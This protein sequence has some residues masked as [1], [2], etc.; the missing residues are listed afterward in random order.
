MY[1]AL[2]HREY[3]LAFQLL[4]T[5]EVFGLLVSQLSILTLNNS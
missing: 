3:D 5:L 2:E 4:E 1:R